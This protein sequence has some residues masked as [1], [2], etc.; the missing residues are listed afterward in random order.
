MEAFLK[1][2]YPDSDNIPSQRTLLK[3]LEN[4]PASTTK[5]LGGINP[6]IENCKQS[7]K[8]LHSTLDDLVKAESRKPPERRICSNEDVECLRENIEIA[9]RYML[10]HYPYKISENHTEIGSHCIFLGCSDKDKDL[11]SNPCDFR[12]GQNQERAH[13][14]KCEFC[15]V[16]PKLYQLVTGLVDHLKNEFSALDYNNIISNLEIGEKY[17]YDYMG[18]IMRNHMQHKRWTDLM[19]G[20]KLNEA[21]CIADFSMKIL[22]KK[23]RE[24]PDSWFA[25]ARSSIH[26]E[27]KAP[28]FFAT[29]K[30]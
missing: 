3:M 26:L 16:T 28:A 25:K 19:N 7:Y 6:H 14:R 30:R 2:Q 10:T 21:F 4:I 11:F 24:P 22:P 23:Y 18:A 13:K 9:S 5:S 8:T 17:F 1:E 29:F 15:E 27:R 20:R 12:L